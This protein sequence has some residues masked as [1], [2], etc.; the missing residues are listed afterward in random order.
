L[1]KVGL[2]LP[3]V[4]HTVPWVGHGVPKASNVYVLALSCKVTL[5][6][7]CERSVV[8][9]SESLNSYIIII[10]LGHHSLYQNGELYELDIYAGSALAN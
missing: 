8:R 4:A 3:E 6:N 2:S 7:D 9:I 1:P 10:L 5:K